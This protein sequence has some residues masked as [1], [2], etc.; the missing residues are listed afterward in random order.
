MKHVT[1]WRPDTCDCVLHY[2]W[3]DTESAETR[4]H[5]P[6]RSVTRHD[7][8]VEEIKVCKAH[9]GL[10][11]GAAE[12]VDPVYHYARVAAEN[13]TKNNVISELLAS[14]DLSESVL[15]KGEQVRT[16][17]AGRE[18]EWSF[19]EDRVLRVK[20]AGG[21]PKAKRDAISQAITSKLLSVV[22]E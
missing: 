11:L 2:E 17:R 20:L 9:A 4:T 22:I 18:P 6:V 13:Q 21:L 16:F 19:D 8:I 5:T 10:T 3:D 1:T 12:D 15:E 7:G 14:P